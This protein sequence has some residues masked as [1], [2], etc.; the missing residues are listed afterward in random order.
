MPQGAGLL[1]VCLLCLLFGI[2]S[3]I[4]AII[5]LHERMHLPTTWIDMVLIAYVTLVTFSLFWL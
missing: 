1:F 2:L 4:G 3:V 5:V